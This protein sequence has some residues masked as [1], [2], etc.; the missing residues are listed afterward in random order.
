[1]RWYDM[2]AAHAI[3]N[4]QFTCAQYL[5]FLLI[6]NLPSRYRELV[7]LVHAKP[8]PTLFF[9]WCFGSIPGH[10]LPLR[11]SRS[12]SLDTLHSV[13]LLCTSDQPDAQTSTWQHTTLT[14][15]YI[16]APAGILT[17]NPMKQTA[18]DPRGHWDRLVKPLTWYKLVCTN[19]WIKW[20]LQYSTM[21]SRV[22]VNCGVEWRQK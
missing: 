12:H 10:G 22:Q 16:H 9:P 3:N 6:L 20:L 2:I 15:D 1:M 19:E 17:W 21:M 5:E 11:A 7:K 18:E 14:K 8:L 13:E 4:K